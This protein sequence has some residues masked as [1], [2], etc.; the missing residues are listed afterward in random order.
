PSRLPPQGH[1]RIRATA[2]W[3]AGAAAACALIAFC[4]IVLR[5]SVLPFPNR[6]WPRTQESRT[7]LV[8]RLAPAPL[9]VEPGAGSIASTQPAAGAFAVPG[10][11]APGLT[12]GAGPL[13]PF[14]TAPV[15]TAPVGG[16]PAATGGGGGT[17][18][19]PSQGGPTQSSGGGLATTPTSTIPSPT[20]PGGP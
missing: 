12:T 9:A 3:L 1:G 18:P 5:G 8:S 11:V 7:P 2:M 15:T 17:T 14:T 16:G 19:A 20:I 13:A 10:G 4:F 6:D